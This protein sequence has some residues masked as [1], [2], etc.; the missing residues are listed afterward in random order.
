MTK[1]PINDTEFDLQIA[2]ENDSIKFRTHYL[3]LSDSGEY[4]NNEIYQLLLAFNE[5]LT[6][7]LDAEEMSRYA[8]LWQISG[9]PPA[10]EQAP[11][12]DSLTL[13]NQAIIELD[14]KKLY[15]CASGLATLKRLS[16]VEYAHIRG[17]IKE[18]F[19]KKVD[20]SDLNR[21]ITHA[22]R[23]QTLA[24][25]GTK[26]DVADIAQRWAMT[27]R[28]MFGYD[29][30]GQYWRMWNDSYWEEVKEKASILDQYTV[31]ALQEAG[32]PVNSS[33]AINTFQRLAAAHCKRQFI[34]AEDKINFANGT[35]DVATGKLTRYH[36]EDNL[37]YCLSFNYNPQKQYL[38]IAVF[39]LSVIQEK[40]IDND[41]QEETLIPNIYG[42]QA[43]MAHVGLALLGDTKLHKAIIAL[44]VPGSGKST[45]ID[46]LN[47]VCGLL[48]KQYVPYD[49]FSRE[50]E[51]KRA[52][53]THN[54]KRIACMDEV[55][56]DALQDEET[57]KSMTAHSGV[58]MRGLNRDEQVDNQWIPKIFM[59]AN[60]DPHY[61]DI[62]GAIKRRLIII[63]TPIQRYDEPKDGQ[64]GQDTLLFDRFLPELEGF[65]VTCLHYALEVRK[66]GYYPQSAAMKRD[67]NEIASNGNPL[68][69]C[70]EDRFILETGA[71]ETSETLHGVYVTYC[72][73]MGK[74]IKPLARP[75]FSS[76]LCG[77]NIG[78]YAKRYKGD[79]CLY[80]IRLRTDNDPK[81]NEYSEE[82]KYQ[83]SLASEVEDP[84]TDSILDGKVDSVDSELTA[85]LNH[86][87]ASKSTPKANP[88]E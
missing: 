74:N 34:P 7:P 82:G 46:L 36:K 87:Q 66:R 57:F 15:Q 88:Q 44:G 27:Y 49:V 59:V 18:K 42:V 56:A 54:K 63:R 85:K 43:V 67:L 12:E 33:H 84:T 48:P 20:W 76:A 81:P 31:A 38:A 68:K 17:E 16:P 25:T 62:S 10:T 21:A 30:D 19:G 32:K 79:R 73:R 24:E 86:R 69:A 60:D 41:T 77:M 13:Y 71:V 50:L 29:A 40:H 70:I 55:P 80:G 72:E 61:K 52:R 47:A 51:G 64:P 78:I 75:N 28:E 23:Q 39:L 6:Y 3:E 5:T 8:E 65:V 83:D 26:P 37:T 22:E 2:R 11:P 4:D 14:P 53:Y 35:L 9:T 1:E 45:L 58:S